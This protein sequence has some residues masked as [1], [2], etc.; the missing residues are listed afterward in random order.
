MKKDYRFSVITVRDVFH[1]HMKGTI[2][3]A[4]NLKDALHVVGDLLKEAGEIEHADSLKLTISPIRRK[5]K[6]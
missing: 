3:G 5:T 1:R 6:N 2:D 4:R